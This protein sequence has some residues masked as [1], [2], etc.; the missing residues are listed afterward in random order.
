MMDQQNHEVATECIMHHLQIFQLKQSACGTDVAD[1]LTRIIRLCQNLNLAKFSKRAFCVRASV[2][3]YSN[4]SQLWL[5]LVPLQ[6]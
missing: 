3:S 6:Q 4:L 5:Q 1:C 2:S